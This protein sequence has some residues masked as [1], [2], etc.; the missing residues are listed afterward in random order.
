M[1]TRVVDRAGK[2]GGEIHI[3]ELRKTYGHFTAVDSISLD[4]KA[5]EFITLLGA[6]GSGKTT[7]LMMIA[8]FVDPDSGAIRIDGR[9]II[10]LPPEQRNLGVVFQN[11]A[12]FPHLT[13]F[14]NIAFPLSLCGHARGNIERRVKDVLSLV[15]LGEL[16]GRRIAQLSGGQQQRVAL[17]RAIVFEP[18]V[19]LM[20][21]P[22]GALDRKLRDQLQG[23]IKR[24]QRDLG[25]TVVYV[26]H[27]QEE[28]LAMSDRVAIMRQGRIVQ[29]GNP[30]E[31]YEQPVSPFVASF[32][33][34]SNLLN[35][36]ATGEQ[37]ARLRMALDGAPSCSILGRPG[38]NRLDGEVV[39]VVRPEVILLSD[40]TG[41]Q[42]NCI[43]G[44]VATREFMGA[45]IRLTVAT[46][47]GALLVRLPRTSPESS[48]PVGTKIVVSWAAK[49]TVIFPREAALKHN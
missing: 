22:L 11:Y 49:D 20:D 7:T 43:D 6:S 46:A 5:G 1:S 30:Y 26:T 47:A 48:V 19:L 25:V 4:V 39:A 28:A 33:G 44:V 27:D 9:D 8:G 35:G 23:E 18:P 17:A 3:A 12:L 21:E 38:G 40:R 15:D 32:L 14:E 16:A 45:T 10:S 29:L 34:E 37:S 36:R 41:T 24:V 2:A 42:E 13:V 31:V